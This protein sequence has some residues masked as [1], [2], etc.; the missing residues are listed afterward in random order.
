MI[1][2]AIDEE[3]PSTAAS[4]L[5]PLHYAL[6][7]CLSVLPQVGDVY[8]RLLVEQTLS[9]EQLRKIGAQQLCRHLVV[10]LRSLMALLLSGVGKAQP[11]EDGTDGAQGWQYNGSVQEGAEGAE[12]SEGEGDEEGGEEEEGEEGEGHTFL[13][14]GAPSS[15]VVLHGSGAGPQAG[16]FRIPDEWEGVGPTSTTA[17]GTARKGAKSK[18]RSNKQQLSQGRQYTT[19][20]K[21]VLALSSIR[22]SAGLRVRDSGFRVRCFGFR[23][24]VTFRLKVQG[25]GCRALGTESSSETVAYRQGHGLWTRTQPTSSSLDLA[26]CLPCWAPWHLP[27]A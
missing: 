19:A 22:V 12:E 23:T 2:L 8:L 5:C 3:G 18:R 7:W 17:S 15:A 20:E 10:Y 4:T 24:W 11:S 13:G 9:G 27:D 16:G 14:S 26:S 6:C 25:S 1:Q 21:I